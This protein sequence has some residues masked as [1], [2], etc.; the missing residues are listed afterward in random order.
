MVP[1][2]AILAGR[3]TCLYSNSSSLYCSTTHDS[4]PFNDND[5]QVGLGRPEL[6]T[7]E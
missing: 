5:E 4:E 1:C 7:F 2:L 3:I 6:E